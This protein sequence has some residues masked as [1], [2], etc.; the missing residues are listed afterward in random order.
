MVTAAKTDVKADRLA[1]LVRELTGQVAELSAVA[2]IWQKRCRGLTEQLALAALQEP[3]DATLGASTATQ[4]SALSG[5]PLRPWSRSWAVYSAIGLLG[6][7]LIGWETVDLVVADR[8][9]YL[10]SVTTTG[11]CPSESKPGA[12]RVQPT[13]QQA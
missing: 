7:Q 8:L 3:Q 4:A 1:D 11:S 2:A 9:Q 12:D 13:A 10:G 5:Q 6:A